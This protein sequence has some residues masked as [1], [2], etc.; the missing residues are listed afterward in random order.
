[1]TDATQTPTLDY[2][3]PSHL[4]GRCNFLP[5][6]AELQTRCRD[7]L[8]ALKAENAQLRE[9]LAQAREAKA[10]KPVR[11]LREVKVPVLPYFSCKP[12]YTVRYDGDG[13]VFVAEHGRT[14]PAVPL[15]MMIAVRM[16]CDWNDDVISQCLALKDDP[17]EP[18]ETV[19]DVLEEMYNVLGVSRIVL[20][21]YHKEVITRLL[22]AVLAE[23]GGDE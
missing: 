17:Y 10:V 16:A 9:E 7:E 23:T 22:A 5:L 2:A 20:P 4:E 18:V 11:K 3:F 1:M 19:E 21:E 8:T 6:S 13:F 12:V 14:Q 15:A